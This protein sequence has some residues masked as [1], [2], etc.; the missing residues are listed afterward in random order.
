MWIQVMMVVGIALGNQSFALT[1]AQLSGAM[2]KLPPEQRWEALPEQSVIA[3]Q[4]WRSLGGARSEG[5]T[6]ESLSDSPSSV[7]I[8]PT[9]DLPG[10]FDWR[11]DKRGPSI[12]PPVMAQGECGSCVA[13]AAVA[14]LE[15]ALGIACDVTGS[16]IRLSA[17]YL[18]S[19]GGGQCRSGWKLS[20]AVKFLSAQGVPDHACMPYQSSGGDDVSCSAACRDAEARRIQGVLAEQPTQGFIEIAEV[21]RAIA[22]A[23]VL[24]NMVLYEDLEHYKSGIYRH[25]AGNQLGSHAIVLVGWSDEHR[26]WIARNSWGPAWGQAGY[27]EVAWDDV[28]LP[29]RYTWLFDTSRAVAKGACSVRY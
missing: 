29:A 2:K 4:D 13:V 22:K 10:E 24:A 6:L 12:L 27:F 9:P 19:C 25:V 17:Q 7:I 28:T 11:K 3:R 15:A 26:S 20:E 21:K 23:P 1:G 5:I 14:A 18:F 8:E 16:P